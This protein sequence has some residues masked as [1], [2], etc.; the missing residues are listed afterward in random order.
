MPLVSFG[1]MVLSV[2]FLRETKADIWFLIFVIGLVL[3][4]LFLGDFI[5]YVRPQAGALP[6]GVHVLAGVLFLLGVASAVWSWNEEDA[7]WYELLALPFFTGGSVY[8]A[9]IVFALPYLAIGFVINIPDFLFGQP[10]SI[11]IV[12]LEFTKNYLILRGD[13]SQKTF[14]FWKRVERI[15]I[16]T[17]NRG[18]FEDD[19]WWFFDDE[20]LENPVVIGSALEGTDQFFTVLDT[21]FQ[22]YDQ[23]SLE[24]ALAS[25]KDNEF[26]IWSK[27]DN[28]SN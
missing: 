7:V 18:P 8:L 28:A 3:F 1:L 25:N 2:Y 19:F 24:Q 22:G 9:L 26:L 11:E 23:S 4:V 12:E 17:T 5:E 10:R 15:R 6:V 13:N 27:G 21:H 20:D 14:L 16:I